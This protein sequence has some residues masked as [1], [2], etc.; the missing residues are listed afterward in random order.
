[1]NTEDLIKPYSGGRRQDWKGVSGLVTIAVALRKG[2][3]EGSRK[4]SSLPVSGS[5][6]KPEHVI[7]LGTT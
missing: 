5:C 1:M 4:G 6:A 2:L 7:G 3:R